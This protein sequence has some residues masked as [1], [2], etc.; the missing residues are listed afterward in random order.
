[1]GSFQRLL[2]NISKLETENGEDVVFT[3]DKIRRMLFG[4]GVQVLTKLFSFV[5]ESTVPC[6]EQERTAPMARLHL[7]YSG[8]G[9]NV[10]GDMPHRASGEKDVGNMV[11]SEQNFK[12]IFVETFDGCYDSGLYTVKSFLL[13]H[14]AKEI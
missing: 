6:S 2:Q 11:K 5:T 9:A 3:M 8:N 1:M 13:D 12:R 14:T 4:K 7:T 10:T